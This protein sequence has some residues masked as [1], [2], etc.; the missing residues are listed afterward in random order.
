M[1]D[2]SPE[3]VQKPKRVRS[4]T[5]AKP[6]KSHAL[7]DMPRKTGYYDES[8]LVLLNVDGAVVPGYVRKYFSDVIVPHSETPE[9]KKGQVVYTST[10]DIVLEGVIGAVG[11]VD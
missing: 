10:D 8:D 9:F 11:F 6:V 4:K 2:N 5:V 3:K 1:E 7:P